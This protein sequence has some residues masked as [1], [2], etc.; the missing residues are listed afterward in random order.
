MK[1][2]P[3]Y[4]GRSMKELIEILCTMSLLGKFVSGLLM[5]CDASSQ[6]QLPF[7]ALRAAQQCSS[8]LLCDS[9]WPTARFSELDSVQFQMS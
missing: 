1:S 6:Q 9:M 2:L 4:E 3:R 7:L 8:R 5:M